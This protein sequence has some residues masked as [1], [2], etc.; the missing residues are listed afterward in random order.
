MHQKN[1]YAALLERID[2][3]KHNH[4][5]TVDIDLRIA[6]ALS[7]GSSIK[8]VSFDIP[9]DISTVYRVIK[10]IDKFLQ[11][12]D[13][14]IDIDDVEI[15]ISNDII[16]G[17]WSR[18]SAL[19][20]DLYFCF[21]ALHKLGRTHIKGSTVKLYIPR[22]RNKKQRDAILEELNNLTVLTDEEKPKSI[23]IFDFVEYIDHTYFFDLTEEAYP[24]YYP[25]YPLL[26]RHPE[27][28]TR[29]K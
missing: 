10:R 27:F 6:E 22:L 23:K 1:L 16:T 26:R 18:Q 28:L 25:L 3:Y 15:A 2:E 24:Y 4:V 11:G 17:R 8:R 19:G 14:Y 21:L 5:Q 12:E 29:H 13:D 9:C 7:K 20:M